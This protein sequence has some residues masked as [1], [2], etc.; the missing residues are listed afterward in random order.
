MKVYNIFFE[1]RDKLAFS[2]TPSKKIYNFRNKRTVNGEHVCIPSKKLF[3]KY[4]NLN[5]VQ[6]DHILSAPILLYHL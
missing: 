2:A 6:I 4:Q 1:F 5:F 3:K